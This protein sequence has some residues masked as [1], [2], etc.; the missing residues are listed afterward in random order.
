M[1]KTC[2]LVYIFF[3]LICT[4]FFYVLSCKE[5]VHGEVQSSFIKIG[6]NVPWLYA[7][8][9]LVLSNFFSFSRFLFY[10]YKYFCLQYSTLYHANQFFIFVSYTISKYI[11]HNCDQLVIRTQTMLLSLPLCQLLRYCSSS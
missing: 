10:L 5:S 1:N 8:V 3:A 7:S 11:P 2:V 6:H 4:L 9:N